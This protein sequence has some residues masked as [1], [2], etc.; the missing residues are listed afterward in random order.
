V[1][2]GT[3]VVSGAVVASGAIVVVGM[4]VVSGASVLVV[5]TVVSGAEKG[6]V[7]GGAD[8]DSIGRVVSVSPKESA[9]HPKDNVTEITKI[10]IKIDFITR[11]KSIT[12]FYIITQ[13]HT[14]CN[15]VGSK[16]ELSR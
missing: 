6:S 5:L 8:V 7:D 4:T 15:I 2:S 12:S 11:F 10:D 16:K 13:K 1:I 9:A 3:A 14:F